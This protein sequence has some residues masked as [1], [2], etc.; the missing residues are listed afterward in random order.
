MNTDI[1]NSFLGTVIKSIYISRKH[2]LNKL[3]KAFTFCMITG[4]LL[5][6]GSCNSDSD[7]TDVPEDEMEVEFE[8]TDAEKTAFQYSTHCGGCHG[9]NFA[10]FVE[11]EWAYG[12]SSEA[13]LNSINTGYADNGMPAYG[14]TFD[15]E[16]IKD[17]A[18]Y[19]LTEIEG[20]T[21]E[22][23]E[24]EN[25][26]LSGLI[27][28]D[29]LSF[30]LETM[31]DDIPG[32]PWGIVQLPNG[33]ILVTEISGRLFLIRT[34]K[35]LVEIS[36]VPDVVASGQ[37]G[38]LD[39]LIHPDFDTNSLVYLS[40]SRANPDNTSQ[41]T[42]A[43]ARGTLS[44]T[45]LENVETIFTALPYLN[46]GHHFGSRLL[47]DQEGYLYVSVGDRGQRD[48][49][50][51]NLDNQLGKIHRIHDDGE[52]PT[53]NPFINE[54]GA[55][56][57]IFTY[58]TR[59]PQGMSL[60]PVTGAVWEGE[61]GPQGGD[62]VNILEAGNNNGWPVISY[63]INYDGTTFTDITEMAGMEQPVHHW[64]PSIAPCGMSFLS[65]GF[66]GAWENDLFVGSLKFEYLHRLKMS[67]NVV[68]G[69]EELV[70]G[71]GRVRDVHMGSDGYIYL[72]VQGSNSV[73]RLV[74]E[75]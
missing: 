32:T 65:G 58:G 60:H 1:Q 59:N 44:G 51:Q 6:M 29:D 2:S 27:V 52:I 71:I 9:Q 54:Q 68:V 50:P 38:L 15:D 30:R 47:F 23:L 3:L 18:D 40:Y 61:H 64:T 56:G 31:T 70:Q 69:H 22:M 16:E 43:V 41:R 21:K 66:Y 53:N 28:S 73:V 74:P 57:S 35:E 63:G 37:G 19:I 39:V 62:E 45:S 72:A 12:N 33:E 7:V 11:R 55:M 75:Q 10:S 13:I 20:K 67:G 17:L 48:T 4:L 36:G 5:V 8:G 42:T 24:S 46:S 49:Y 25:P 34:D 14:T 26:D